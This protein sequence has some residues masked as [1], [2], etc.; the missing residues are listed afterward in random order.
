MEVFVWF[1]SRLNPWYIS[2]RSNPNLYSTKIVM[3]MRWQTIAINV[4]MVLPDKFTRNI[5]HW[6]TV[7]TFNSTVTVVGRG[8]ERSTVSGTGLGTAEV[9]VKGAVITA[10]SAVRGTPRSHKRHSHGP[11]VSAVRD[12]GWGSVMSVTST[13]SVTGWGTVRGVVSD[14]AWGIVRSAVSGTVWGTVRSAVSGTGWGTARST[15]SSTGWGTVRSAASGAE[16]GTV[17]SA[18]SGAG[19]GTVSSTDSGTVWGTVRSAVSATGWGTVRSAVNGT[20]WGTGMRAVWSSVLAQLGRSI[21]R[22]HSIQRSLW[23]MLGTVRVQTHSTIALYDPHHLGYPDQYNL[24]NSSNQSDMKLTSDESDMMNTLKLCCGLSLHG[25][26]Y[27][28]DNFVIRTCST[29]NSIS[30]NDNHSPHWTVK[31]SLIVATILTHMSY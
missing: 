28:A 27:R 12:M 22:R 29:L 20:G 25:Q 2:I 7:N 18:V 11:V 5:F 16:G 19:W 13:I 14:A 9:T 31:T 1:K 3:K 30:D 17:S 26:L 24:G 6:G 15:V 8:A 21:Q 4:S 10:V 23:H